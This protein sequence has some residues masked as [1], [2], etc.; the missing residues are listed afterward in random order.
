MKFLFVGDPH[1][2]VNNLDEMQKLIN[3]LADQPDKNKYDFILL[4][5]D[6]FN[7]HSVV[8]LEVANFWKQAI[9]VLTK[10]YTKVVIL[11]GNHDL[12][13][14]KQMETGLSSIHLVTENNPS[15]LLVDKPIYY[16][17]I[18]LLPY[19]SDSEYFYHSAENL[20]K[21]G[22]IDLLICHQ[23]IDGAKY[24]NGFYAPEGLD[25]NRIPQTNIVSGHIH[26]FQEFGK[27]LFPGTARWETRSDA[28]QNKGI[29]T[30]ELNNGKLTKELIPTKSVVTPI[31]ELIINEGDELPAIQSGVKT[32]IELVGKSEWIKKTKEQYR[33]VASIKT[34]HKDKKLKLGSMAKSM[35]LEEYLDTYFETT[36]VS[37][38]NLK[39][40]IKNL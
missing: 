29:W 37:K 10:N 33:G 14:T 35:A 3:F 11:V 17:G 2:K 39:E 34:T 30:I 4:A 40:A 18:G 21:Q 9:Q 36:L 23:T 12:T 19:T 32:Y 24:D 5:G 31:V 25:Q 38:Q 8:R 1:A 15:V 27:V 16:N 6:L 13:G 28:N 26:T 20:F 22:A 7:D